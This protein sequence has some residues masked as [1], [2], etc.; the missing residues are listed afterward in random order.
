MCVPMKIDATIS[1]RPSTEIVRASL[2]RP[3]SETPR[4]SARKIG[5]LPSGLTMGNNAPLTSNVLATN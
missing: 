1:T 3:W 5:A 4:V 2:A